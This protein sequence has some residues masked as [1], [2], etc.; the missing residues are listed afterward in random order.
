MLAF[1][2]QASSF[3]PLSSYPPEC[4]FLGKFTWEKVGE[5]LPLVQGL[6]RFLR[7]GGI[8]LL[9]LSPVAS[10]FQHFFATGQG[11][12]VASLA[13]PYF[14]SHNLESPDFQDSHYQMCSLHLACLSTVVPGQRRKRQKSRPELWSIAHWDIGHSSAGPSWSHLPPAAPNL[15]SA[16]FPSQCKTQPTPTGLEDKYFPWKG[17]KWDKLGHC[18]MGCFSPTQNSS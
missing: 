6:L 13:R 14:K 7:C 12:R 18:K 2:Y 10:Q 1:P 4:K 16:A 15:H 5:D 9:P 3:A 8:R 17:H 11:S